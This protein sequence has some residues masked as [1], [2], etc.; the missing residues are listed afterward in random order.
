[1]ALWRQRLSISLKLSCK[2]A[3]A[4]TKFHAYCD[5]GL[6]PSLGPSQRHHLPN[7]D[8]L[9]LFAF[10]Q[11]PRWTRTGLTREIWLYYTDGVTRIE[12]VKVMGSIFE[13]SA[14]ESAETEFTRG[15]ESDTESLFKHSVWS[16]K[17][18]VYLFVVSRGEG[19]N[20]AKCRHFWRY[21]TNHFPNTRT[22]TATHQ[23]L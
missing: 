21:L 6:T 22:P 8:L 7:T 14:G 2:L 9:L 10:K 13:L 15:S 19:G 5:T 20:T 23:L 17:H 16:T 12:M 3:H 18:A 11:F 1:M 4:R